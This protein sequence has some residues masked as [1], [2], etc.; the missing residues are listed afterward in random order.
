MLASLAGI[1]E[2][3]AT[4]IGV[5]NRRAAALSFARAYLT[6]VVYATCCEFALSNLAS[7][8]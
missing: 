8:R 7:G 2:Y 3:H 4:G 5:L 1:L 6:E